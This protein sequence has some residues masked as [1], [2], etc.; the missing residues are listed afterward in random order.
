M[1]VEV[2][3]S[4]SV[5]EP[6]GNKPATRHQGNQLI[7]FL[8]EYV[9]GMPKS[10]LIPAAS[11]KTLNIVK[12]CQDLARLHLVWFLLALKTTCSIWNQEGLDAP[13]VTSQ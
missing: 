4:N 12:I 9:L 10:Q 5:Q 13:T 6:T 3:H 7:D 11:L 2:E 8:T 1:N